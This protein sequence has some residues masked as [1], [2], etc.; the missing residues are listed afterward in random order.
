MRVLL[1]RL[2]DQLPL[3]VQTLSTDGLSTGETEVR[4]RPN[5]TVPERRTWERTRCDQHEEKPADLNAPVL[6]MRWPDSCSM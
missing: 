3:S 1:L 5:Q 6:Q 2:M 4:A